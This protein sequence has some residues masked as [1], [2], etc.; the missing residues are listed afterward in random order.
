VSRPSSWPI[1]SKR[2][3]RGLRSRPNS[4]AQLTAREA[5][6]RLQVQTK[7]MG[8]AARLRYRGELFNQNAAGCAGLVSVACGHWEHAA[9]FPKDCLFLPTP[10]C[11]AP[12]PLKEQYGFHWYEARRKDGS[13]A[14]TAIG[15]GGQ[16]LVVILSLNLL[17]V[18]F[19]GNYFALTN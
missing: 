18:V 12:M 2:K 16:R 17:Y 8:R 4:F 14:C 3:P 15:F 11:L 10:S 13:S 7:T 19:I 6:A 5:A 1:S 9:T